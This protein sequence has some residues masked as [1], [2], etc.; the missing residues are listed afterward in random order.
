MISYKRFEDLAFKAKGEAHS[1]V[2]QKAAVEIAPEVLAGRDAFVEKFATIPRLEQ[3]VSV[4]GLD[5]AKTKEFIDWVVQDVEK[6]S[7]A[8]LEV[9]GL[10]WEDM[11][12]GI[13]PP[14]RTYYITKVKAE[15][16]G[17]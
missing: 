4:V 8:E 6:E 12:K 17:V 16:H 15:V 1:V 10:K 2:K 3:G 9:S 7:K 14:A 13:I 11:A 5:L